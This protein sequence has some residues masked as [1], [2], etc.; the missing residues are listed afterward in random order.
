MSFSLY[1]LLGFRTPNTPIS[2]VSNE[3]DVNSINRANN[4]ESKGIKLDSIVT[5]VIRQ[6]E[7]RAIF[8]FKKYGTNLDRTDL[9]I[10]DWIQHAQEEHMDAI[11]Y[12]EKLKTEILKK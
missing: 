3:T 12:L 4:P 7:D 9:S 2:T 8:G 11:L 6:F 10:F 1:N 5:S